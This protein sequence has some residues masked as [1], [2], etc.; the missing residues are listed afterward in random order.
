ML[1]KTGV[2]LTALLTGAGVMLAGC[3]TFPP[4]GPPPIGEGCQK[5]AAAVADKPASVTVGTTARNY[6]WS[7]SDRSGPKPLV[8]DFHGLIE[9]SVGVHPTMSQFTPKAQAEGF[10]VAYPVGEG[11]GLNW[12]LT[13]NGPS[14]QF[15]DQLLKQVKADACID[16]RRIYATGLSYGAFMT[17]SLM[18]YRSD[19][20]AAA[21]PV[22][23]IMNP[24]DCNPTRKI[25]FVTFHGTADPILAY[26][27]FSGTPQA[28]A[29]R[30]GCG[31]KATTTVVASDATIKQPI[32]KDTW[33]CQAQGTA[34][35]FYRIEGGGHA[36]PGSAFST[37][38]GGI[39][40]PTATSINATDIM[41]DFF[42]RFSL[43]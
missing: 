40:G 28:W 24:G 7:A 31:A 2:V 33:D 32:Y 4:P 20:F 10:V 38:I 30:Y 16:A 19:V 21:A 26:S 13:S 3:T 1:K 17:S 15:V 23:G 11:G 18:C 25:P 39:V 42:K 29:T 34:A 36:W 27:G 43:P 5:P 9:G 14:V 6:T 12:D 35:E 22:A 41:W 37:S 8:L